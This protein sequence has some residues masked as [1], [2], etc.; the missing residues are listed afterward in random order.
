MLTSKLFSMLL[1]LSM[2]V[3]H[4]LNFDPAGQAP[5]I[6]FLRHIGM[7]MLLLE[8]NKLIKAL[9]PLLFNGPFVGIPGKLDTI[10]DFDVIV[11]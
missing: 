5:R 1:L 10:Q 8:D 2:S 6:A 11:R 3:V 7:T 9:F 4:T